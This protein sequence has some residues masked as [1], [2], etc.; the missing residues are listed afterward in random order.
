MV[1]SFSEKPVWKRTLIVLGWVVAILVGLIYLAAEGPPRASPYIA[2][3][4]SS[5]ST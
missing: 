4:R 1:M 2:E 5:D 3:A